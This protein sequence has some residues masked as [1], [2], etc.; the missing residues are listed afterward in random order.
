MVL[1]T[2][3]HAQPD[4]KFAKSSRIQGATPVRP[5]CGGSA[6]PHRGESERIDEA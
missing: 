6:D 5:A 2:T 3:T 4:I 1:D